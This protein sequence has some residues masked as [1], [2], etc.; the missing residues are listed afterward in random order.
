MEKNI[1]FDGSDF[2]PQSNQK[3][4]FYTEELILNLDLN[5]DSL[6]TNVKAYKENPKLSICTKLEFMI[7]YT[8]LEENILNTFDQL[9]SV[10]ISSNQQKRIEVLLTQFNI[11]WKDFQDEWPQDLWSIYEK[12]RKKDKKLIFPN[13]EYLEEMEKSSKEVRIF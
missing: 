4:A 11:Y 2:S 13:L 5:I 3:N 9:N 12:I 8:I 7:E 10:K 1:E 6:M